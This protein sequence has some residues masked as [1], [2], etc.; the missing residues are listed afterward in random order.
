MV[1]VAELL[2]YGAIALTIGITSIGVGIGEGLA[3]SAAIK[4]IDI[5]PGARDEIAKFSIFGIALIETTAILGVTI[6]LMLIMQAR[7]F[8]ISFAQGI[9]ELGMACAICLSGFFIGLVSSY[10]ASEACFAVARQP[11]SGHK[12]LRFMLITQSIIQTPILFGF[13]IA[14]YINSLIPEIQTVHEGIKLLASG[15]CIGLGCIGP[16]IGLA[17]FAKTACQSVGVNRDAYTKL[18]TFTFLS[19]AI[20]ETPIIF[21]LIISLLI[22]TASVGETPYLSSIAFISAA[23]CIGI[24]TINPG[25]NSGK[26]A[27]AACKQIALHPERYALL[28]R[29]SMLGQGII[30]T[31]AVYALLIALLIFAKR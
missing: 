16:A 10:P 15:L 14:V 19:E 30:D 21:A 5:Q 9:A 26:T 31:L 29:V 11:F 28:S 20:I 1:E 23:L 22:L 12:I 18:F 27:S 24:G 7:T 2:H 17:L 4:A 25:I 13:I 6:S 3:N 8:P